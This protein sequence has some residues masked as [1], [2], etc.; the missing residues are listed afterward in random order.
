MERRV[1]LK[2][3]AVAIGGLISLPA[4]AKGWN[5]ASVQSIQPILSTSQDVLLAEVV[6][7]IIPTTNTPGAKELGVHT[8][9]QKMVTD[10]FEPQ[11]Q[12][13]LTKGLD[14]VEA[15]A[16]QQYSQ[17]FAAL[18]ATQRMALLQSLATVDEP[19]KKDFYG[20]VKNLTIRGYLNSEYVMTNLTHYVMAPG[21]YYGCVPV[22][23]NT[24]S[25]KPTK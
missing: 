18:D 21:H 13:T 22:A 23:P 20:L 7:T 2:T 4:W 9:I 6:E 17:A 15:T 16:Q 11:A 8:F 19:G 5:Q 1:A 10:C 12:Q 25:Q 24:V 3:M 14:T